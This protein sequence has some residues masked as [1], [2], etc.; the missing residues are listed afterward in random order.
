[1]RQS[2]ADAVNYKV[3]VYDSITPGIVTNKTNVY[4]SSSNIMT[5]RG[6]H[7]RDMPYSGLL[8]SLPTRFVVDWR[9]QTNAS[10]EAESLGYRRKSWGGGAGWTGQPVLMSW[11]GKPPECIIGSM[12]GNVYS[13]DISSGRLL[14][15]PFDTKNPIKGSISADPSYPGMIYVG[16][17]IRH[18]GVSGARAINVLDSS[19]YV[20]HSADD[21]DAYR[22]W[23]FF[24]SSPI[25]VDSFLFWPAENGILYKFIRTSNGPKI[26]SKLIYRVNGN[27]E[28]GIEASMSVYGNVG[29]IADNGG[30]VLCIDLS[31]LAPL[32]YRA[33]TDDTDATPV[34]SIENDTPFI[35]VGCEVDKQGDSGIAYMR[36][37][38]GLTGDLIWE[39]SIRCRSYRDS[40]HI[41]NGGMLSTP[42]LGRGQQ[43][44]LI[45]T[46]FCR[47][48]QGSSGILVA[49][50]KYSGKRVYS[51]RLSAYTWSSPI[52]FYTRDKHM[53]ICVGDVI[54]GL[55]LIDGA[56]G[57]IL[58]RQQIGSNFEA[59]PVPIGNSCIIASRGRS[60][61]K[62]SLQ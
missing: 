57:N 24:D 29:Y 22:R 1:L 54:G 36:K 26:H 16:Q 42:L 50:D 52:A 49:Y 8:D 38:S 46:T 58:F 14:R 4:D 18:T 51:T 62:C 35:Y 60:I 5:F 10:T 34:V 17:G 28:L 15:E 9:F 61:I 59:S 21:R 47:D 40:M 31:T 20:L 13:I 6:S 19:L 45:V 39:D 53:Y 33:N 23:G 2:S 43:A 3:V 27:R 32:W 30:S 25:I 37:I 48:Q 12:D 7:Q 56:N 41:L 44:N 55:Y 11:N